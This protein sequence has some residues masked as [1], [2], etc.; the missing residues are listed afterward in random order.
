MSKI[1]KI[2]ANKLAPDIIGGIIQAI[3]DKPI[4]NTNWI[5]SVETDK[6]NN[7]T[8]WIKPKATYYPET[9][10]SSTLAQNQPTIISITCKDNVLAILQKESLSKVIKRL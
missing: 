8:V 6:K 3:E 1:E 4:K 10:L 5:E 2:Q 7:W 9:I